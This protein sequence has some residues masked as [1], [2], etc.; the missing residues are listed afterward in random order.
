MND[1]KEPLEQNTQPPNQASQEAANPDEVQQIKNTSHNSFGKSKKIGAG[2]LAILLVV[3]VSLTLSSA[4]HQTNLSEHAS[5]PEPTTP[6]TPVLNPNAITNINSTTATLSSI[7]PD[8]TMGPQTSIGNWSNALPAF[9]KGKLVFA[10]TDPVQN[11]K[12]SDQDQNQKPSGQPT[13]TMP[14]QAQNNNNQDHGEGKNQQTITA[15]KIT[16]TKVEVHIAYQGTPG[17]QGDKPSTTPGQNGHP[18]VSP[19]QQG[20]AVDHWETLNIVNPTT[21]DLVQLAKTNSLSTLGLTN[22]A[23]GKYT[24]VRLYVKS[25]TATVSNGSPVNLTIHG[26][27][28]IVRVV[29]PFTIAANQTT[30]LTM[31]FDAQH[32]VVQANGQWFLKPVVA[33]LIQDHQ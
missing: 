12:P 11:G 29:Q 27:D 21:V 16:V 4:T 26:K 32:S 17:D 8:G 23:A 18:T 33:H 10:V 22:L 2:L 15:L 31:D 6:P 28:N 5:G 14:T 7:N 20:Q 1:N 24:E 19:S 3:G 9:L 30:K 13:H 25:A